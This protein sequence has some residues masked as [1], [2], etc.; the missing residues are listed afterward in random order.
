MLQYQEKSRSD[1]SSQRGHAYIP[2]QLK[3]R[4]EQNTEVTLDDVR[5]HYNSHRPAR[6]DALAY[7][8]GTEVYLGPGQ[9]RYLPHELGHVVQQKLGLVRSDTLHE[10][11]VRMNTDQALERQ[12][13]RIGAGR[14]R[15]SMHPLNTSGRPAVQRMAVYEG[16][17]G[18]RPVI[19][20]YKRSGWLAVR[21]LKKYFT[22]ESIQKASMAELAGVSREKIIP[23][24]D[25]ESYFSNLTPAEGAA[26]AFEYSP[27]FEQIF[28]NCI[29]EITD[30]GGAVFKIW[31]EAGDEFASTLE[32]CKEM[33]HEG[34]A[35]MDE[36][37]MACTPMTELESRGRHQKVE[38]NVELYFNYKKQ[39]LYCIAQKASKIRYKRGSVGPHIA[40]TV[41]GKRI[42]IA[43]NTHFGRGRR[44]QADMRTLMG[45]VRAAINSMEASDIR[46]IMAYEDGHRVD[47]APFELREQG[48][49]NPPV[50]EI[51][52]WIEKLRDYPISVLDA[53]GYRDAD[54]YAA[55]PIHGEMTIMDYM[56]NHAELFGGR[57]N[58]LRQAEGVEEDARRVI[59]IGGTRVDCK[60]CHGL[61][62]KINDRRQIQGNYV[63]SS[64]QEGTVGEN[65]DPFPGT[66]GGTAISSKRNN[67][68]LRR[69]WFRIMH[70]RNPYAGER[71]PLVPRENLEPLR[72]QVRNA[73]G[74]SEVA[75]EEESCG[76]LLRDMNIVLQRLQ[77]ED[78]RR[79]SG[80]PYAETGVLQRAI[81]SREAFV[82]RLAEI[83]AHEPEMEAMFESIFRDVFAKIDG[84]LGRLTSLSE[85]N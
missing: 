21:E 48:V 46:S 27:Y 63:V 23:K 17:D 70:G 10:S 36:E 35:P 71:I 20:R 40:I 33:I 83:Q 11:G 57:D 59:W 1:Q 54:Q 65:R 52:G 53:P 64:E 56:R 74:T 12:A 39:A 32:K 79:S 34:D 2:I 8:Q 13:D 15:L 80:R 78:T 29:K 4:M 31:N 47:N 9:E 58:E 66:E 72:E 55:S 24:Q 18:G 19:S 67:Y 75:R 30:A 45:R 77:W 28:L 50:P 16:T 5:V 37:T 43:N 68:N 73:T 42:Y 14:E 84:L 69:I 85:R 51:M 7:T 60:I 22:E 38:E 3:N 6:L 49:Q 76:E 81:Q 26:G 44:F 41:V 25:A 61:F 62:G 82:G